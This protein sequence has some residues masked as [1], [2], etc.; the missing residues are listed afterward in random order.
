MFTIFIILEQGNKSHHYLN[1]TQQVQ[2]GV[3]GTL[4]IEEASIEYIIHYKQVEE[5]SMM[6]LINSEEVVTLLIKLGEGVFKQVV[7]FVKLVEVVVVNFKLE[8]RQL[9]V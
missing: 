4:V 7:N 1:F 5:V 3:V 2:V 8:A 6:A 9:A